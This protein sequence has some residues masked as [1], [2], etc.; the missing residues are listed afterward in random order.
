MRQDTVYISLAFQNGE[1]IISP[2]GEIDHHAAK[3]LREE[4]D[5]AIRRYKP[6]QVVLRMGGVSFMDS[7][8]LG[9]V[10]G[11]LRTAK[12]VGAGLT[13]RELPQQ[14]RRMFEMA[15]LGRMPELTLE[16]EKTQKLPRQ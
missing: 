6:G 3:L 14:C 16:D 10:V 8:G 12:E 11:R 13:L 7:S 5:K 1:L 9:L 4:M 15:G 2:S